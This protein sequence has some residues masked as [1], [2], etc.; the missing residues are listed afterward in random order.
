MNAKLTLSLD[1]DAISAGKQA[2]RE[3]GRSLS[4]M[5]EQFF[6]L[7]GRD[8]RTAEAVYPISSSLQG[9]VGM[10]AGSFDERDYREHLIKKQ[11]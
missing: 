7:L 11:G 9:L 8:K 5:V 4:G 6:V 10:G 3:S 2:A 1:V